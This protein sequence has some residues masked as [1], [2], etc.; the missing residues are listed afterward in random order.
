MVYGMDGGVKKWYQ[1]KMF[2]TGPIEIKVWCI[3]E[4]NNLLRVCYKVKIEHQGLMLRMD[5]LKRKGFV[6]DLRGLRL[7]DSV[8]K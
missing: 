4:Y 6:L 7:C 5:G 8:I 1:S 3:R 2:N